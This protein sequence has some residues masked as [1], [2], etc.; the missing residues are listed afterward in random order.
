[1]PW[2]AIRTIYLF[3]SKSDGSNV[4]EERVVA[5]EAATRDEAHEKGRLEAEQYARDNDVVPHPEQSGY[6]QDGEALIDNYEL[7][8]ELFEAKLSLEE[9]YDQRYSAYEYSPEEPES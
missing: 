4:F 1:M 8:S 9:F 3:G 5:V 6:E 7:W 2:Y